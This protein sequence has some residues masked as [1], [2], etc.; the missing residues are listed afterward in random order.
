MR[1]TGSCCVLGPTVWAEIALQSGGLSVELSVGLGRQEEG[2][3]PCHCPLPRAGVGASREAAS[4][5]ALGS[6]S[7]AGSNCRER[8]L[9]FSQDP[10]QYL[11]PP[12]IH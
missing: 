10:V 5:W 7:K 8:M 6:I 2:L 3:P 4:R 9:R 11:F 12:H 1:C